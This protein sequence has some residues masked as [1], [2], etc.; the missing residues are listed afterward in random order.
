MIL[1]TGLQGLSQ[2]VVVRWDFP[3]NPDDAI[4]D[5]GAPV[6][7]T[8][9]LTLHGGA[10]N[11]SFNHSGFTTRCAAAQ[12]W[13]NGALTKYWQIEFSTAGYGDLT[14]E[15]RQKSFTPSDF[16]PR[17]FLIQ[18]KIGISPVWT[19]FTTFSISPGN[20]WFQIP[21]TTLP[22]SCDNQASISIRWLMLTNE[23]TQGSGLVIDSAYNRVDDIV[24]RSYCPVPLVTAFPATQTVCPGSAITPI[25]LT[26]TNS[27]P[28][29]TFSWIRD[30]T[31]LITGMAASGSGTPITGTLYSTNPQQPETTVFTITAEAA[32]CSSSTT[33]SVTVLD[34]E[35]PYFLN[36][37]DSIYLCVQD[38]VEAWWDG[39]G[40]FTPE[41]PDYHTF[42]S[43]NTILDLDL[44]T[45][46]DNCSPPEELILHW[47]IELVGGTIIT[48]TGQI[49]MYPSNIQFPLGDNTIIYWLEDPSGNVTPEAGRPVVTVTV[50]AR[51][52]ITRNF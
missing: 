11:L 52:D 28:G 12:L 42:H 49:S 41:R 21:P 5:G 27:V 20:H 33:A 39:M 31:T 9:T 43:G 23:P 17:D 36:F 3:N 44:A 51:P 48:G 8:K 22:A 15:S 13:S 6:N 38:I 40:D 1:A 34:D 14:F 46:S 7:L 50:L 47:R 45:F 24:I 2:S 26:T 10:G 37:P 32:G 30:N 16:G 25:V 18:Y 4:A 35:P 29:T 19:T